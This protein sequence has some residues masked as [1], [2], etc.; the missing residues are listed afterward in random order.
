MVPNTPLPPADLFRQTQPTPC[1]RKLY[2]IDDH[3]F[4]LL[5]GLLLGCDKGL[6]GVFDQVVGVHGALPPAHLSGS[7]KHGEIHQYLQY[8]Q[9]LDQYHA[10]VAVTVSFSKTPSVRRQLGPVVYIYQ[11]VG[12]RGLL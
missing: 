3:L 8:I 5:C 1:P 9:P 4:P 2:A 6:V 7:D 12:C 10:H 11:R